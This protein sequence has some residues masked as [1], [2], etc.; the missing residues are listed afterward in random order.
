MSIYEKLFNT[1]YS[2]AKK[3][4]QKALPYINES[5][6]LG[7]DDIDDDEDE[8]EYR[9][10]TGLDDWLSS[11]KWN[12]FACSSIPIECANAD[13]SD[14][15]VVSII[16]ED[17]APEGYDII[18]ALKDEC[19]TVSSTHTS[20]DKDVFAKDYAFA[21]NGDLMMVFGIKV[22][23]KFVEAAKPEERKSKPLEGSYEALMEDTEPVPVFTEKINKKDM[24]F[25]IIQYEVPKTETEYDSDKNFLDYLEEAGFDYL[26]TRPAVD[27]DYVRDQTEDILRKIDD[28]YYD[29]TEEDPFGE[30]YR[31]D[32]YNMNIGYTAESYD[33]GEET[34]NTVDLYNLKEIFMR[35]DMTDDELLKS[36]PWGL[37]GITAHQFHKINASEFSEETF[38]VFAS[39]MLNEYVINV[40]PDVLSRIA[41]ATLYAVANLDMQTIPLKDDSDTAY[42]LK[43]AIGRSLNEAIILTQLYVDYI[44]AL[45]HAVDYNDEYIAGGADEPEHPY[46]N[47]PRYPKPSAIRDFH[48]KAARDAVAYDD[49]KTSEN[50]KKLNGLIADYIKTP[51]Y[52]K[53]L[54][55]GA[56]YSIIEATCVED[57][58][59]E[60]DT[61]NHCIGTYGN[62]FA[63]RQ[64]AIYFARRNDEIDTPFYSVEIIMQRGHDELTQLYTYKDSTE[65]SA[66][67]ENFVREWCKAKKLYIKC[68][69]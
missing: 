4:Y 59:R 48:D 40:I 64:C 61:L 60:G 47:Y 8:E 21:F 25:S 1:V 43:L 50:R 9:G 23:D 17:Y 67:F 35:S 16:R 28:G 29:D 57:L 34:E 44:A 38:G 20:V 66:D 51:E 36:T 13:E 30:N 37:L 54:Y 39:R 62:K 55:K 31:S 5:R 7:Y 6:G 45:P 42:I 49:K 10:D 3:L 46:Y 63:T 24:E 15:I 53:F 32:L 2:E 11:D 41:Y 22:P 69:I 12:P 52:R 19:G 14:R 18:L 58:I 56:K 68:E 65:K 26:F 27:D 33:C